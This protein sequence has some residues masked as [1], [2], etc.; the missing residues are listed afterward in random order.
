M[1]ADPLVWFRYQDHAG[2]VRRLSACI[3]DAAIILGVLATP[4][5]LIQKMHLDSQE[6]TAARTVGA[7]AV[8][9][10]GL[11]VS[12]LVAAPYHLF[13]RRTRGGT[14]GYRLAGVRLVT[15]TDVI[16]SWSTLIRRFALSLIIPLMLYALMT[17]VLAA[18][19]Q[20]DAPR[21]KQASTP[22]QSV[23]G[24]IM[25]S[26][27]FVI[28]FGNYWMIIRDPRRQA[29]HDKWSR[30]W[31]VRSNARPAGAGSPIERAW[32]FG[33]LVLSYWDVEPSSEPAPVATA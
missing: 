29:L 4:G 5:I 31:V 24:A 32:V 7:T 2:I 30:T 20:L 25:F 6:P 28:I 1:N 18:R 13:L 14:I 12:L 17:P 21:H 26:I 16:P 10:F 3:I 9:L 8:M 23:V 19:G 22:G 11:L 15:M 33:P 27:F